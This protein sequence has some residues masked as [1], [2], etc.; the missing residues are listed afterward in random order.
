MNQ[1]AIMVK[2]PIR[3]KIWEQ[4]AALARRQRRKPEALAASVL[5]DYIQQVEDEELLEETTQAAQRA[6]YREEDVE[7][8]IRELRRKL[9][10]EIVNGCKEEANARSS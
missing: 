9:R 7:E 8:L 6:G 10:A 4:F 1:E 5:R 3:E 2:V